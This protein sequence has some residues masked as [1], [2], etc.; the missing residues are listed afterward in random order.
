MRSIL[1]W[2]SIIELISLSGIRRFLRTFS[3]FTFWFTV[4]GWLMSLTWTSKSWKIRTNKCSVNKTQTHNW[5]FE[6]FS[7]YWMFDIF[8]GGREGINELVRQLGQETNSV[9]VQDCHVIRQL[10]CMNCNIQGG[11][12]LVFG[13][14]TTVTSEG[15]NQSCFSC[16]DKK[17]IK[18]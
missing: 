2:T 15:F 10:A 4:S 13:L 8:Q 12:K 16:S 11:E 14:K 5:N 6:N 7:P 1:L 9:H 18:K 17:K 3:T